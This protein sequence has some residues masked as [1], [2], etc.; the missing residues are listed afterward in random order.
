MPAI[1]TSLFLLG[2]VAGARSGGDCPVARVPQHRLPAHLA[3]STSQRTETIFRERSVRQEDPESHVVSFLERHDLDR[4]S[5]IFNCRR[6]HGRHSRLACSPVGC[7]P[8]WMASGK[9][10][11]LLGFGK[12]FARKCACRIEQCVAHEF[13]IDHRRSPC[14]IFQLHVS[15]SKA[16]LPAPIDN[17][18]CAA[19]S[20]LHCLPWAMC[21]SASAPSCA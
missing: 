11:L 3:A 13:A 15:I 12:S 2:V 19:E 9:G 17:T 7:Q 1:R 10:R 6:H 21:A 5:L 14:A 8:L 4:E 18:S 20:K 16:P